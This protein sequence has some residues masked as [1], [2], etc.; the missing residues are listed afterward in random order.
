MNAQI[1]RLVVVT[2]AMFM[3]L[4]IAITAVQFVYAP[5]LVS[6]QRNARRYLQ[7][8]ERDRGPI[9]VAESPVAYSEKQ[10]GDTLFQRVYPSGPLYASVTGYFAAM[11]QSATGIEAAENEVLEGSTS[12]LLWQRLRNLIAGNPRQGGGVQLTVDPEMQQVAAEMLGDRSG[13]VVALDVTTGA[14]LTLY[15]S[16]TFDP[17]QLASNDQ[18]AAEAAAVALEGDSSRPLDNRAIASNRYAPGSTFK[19]LT[20]IAMLESGITPSTELESPQNVLLP[21]TETTVYN[22]DQLDCGSGLVSLSEAFARSCNTTFVLA[23]Q[24]LPAGALQDVTKRFGFGE[25]I[26][27]PLTVT[28]SVFPEN[29]DPAQLA[30]SSFG[31][32]E[33]QMTPMEMAMVVAAIAN[34]GVMMHPYLVQSVVDADNQVVSTT[35]P[36]VMGNPVTAAIAE[37]IKQMMV[38]AV[39]LPY[40]SAAGAA[41]EGIQVAAKTGTAEVGENNELTNAL[42]VAFAPA[43]NPQIAVAVVVEGRAGDDPIFGASAAAPIAARLLEVGLQ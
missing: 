28:P 32:F 5:A 43:D 42:T 16:P 35:A 36:Q 8:A 31:Q 39:S 10:E 21:G 25:T 19:I 9:I 7:S 30:L 4:G 11:S 18:A 3:V 2:F 12:Q 33:V 41:V 37:E 26:K 40:G 29:P 14:V 27:I 22:Y 13:A 15:S 20:S 17:N 6:D 23:S 38:G 34:G 1:R 24:N